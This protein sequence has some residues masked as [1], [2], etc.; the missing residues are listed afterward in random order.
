MYDIKKPYTKYL[1]LKVY[2]LRSYSEITTE[3]ERS[4]NTKDN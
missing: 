1:V 4:T 3:D 2:S